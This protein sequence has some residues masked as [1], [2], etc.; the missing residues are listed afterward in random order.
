M[1]MAVLFLLVISLAGLVATICKQIADNRVPEIAVCTREEWE[2]AHQ[3]K[4]EDPDETKHINEALFRMGY[5]RE[6]VP[7]SVGDQL[8]QPASQPAS[9]ERRGGAVTCI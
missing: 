2:E 6:D 1:S 8:S 4:Q 3:E 5:L 7:L 9:I